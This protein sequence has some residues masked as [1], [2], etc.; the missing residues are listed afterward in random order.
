MTMDKFVFVSDTHFNHLNIIKYCERPFN[1]VW[2]M[3][4]TMRANLEALDEEGFRI[5]HCGD[6]FFGKPGAVKLN[7]KHPENHIF[8]YGNH[9]DFEPDVY[10]KWFGTV[11]GMRETWKKHW[12]KLALP[13]GTNV[14][15]SHEPQQDLHGCDYNLYGH[16]HN[17]MTRY[18]E[19]FVTDYPWLFGSKRH[20]NVGVELTG[21]TALPL[22]ELIKLPQPRIDESVTPTKQEY[23]WDKSK[24]VIK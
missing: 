19:K 18:P 17:N 8:I 3:N 21:Y 12:M 15:L 11:H 7:F 23:K 13:D 20:I 10:K 14:L 5:V 22:E 24:W 16:H 9:D 1:T 4:E 2:Y 6:M